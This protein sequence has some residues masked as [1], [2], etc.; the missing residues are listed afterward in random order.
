MAKKTKNKEKKG[1][2]FLKKTA[3]LMLVLLGIAFFLA[4][5]SY[6]QNDFSFNNAKDGVAQN[7]LGFWGASVADVS[8]GLGLAL[9]VFMIC[10]FVWGYKLFRYGT[11][12][13]FK[14]RLLA[15]VFGVLSLAP[16]LKRKCRKKLR[17]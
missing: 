7:W 4:I 5:F 16:F 14:W 2:I 11:L 8:A 12:L 6:H 9:P 13:L 1:Y 15:F 3:G 10:F 17:A